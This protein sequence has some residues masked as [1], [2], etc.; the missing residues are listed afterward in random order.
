LSFE[1]KLSTLIQV[2]STINAFW[3][4]SKKL[5]LLEPPLFSLNPIAIPPSLQDMAA[6]MDAM[7]GQR[8]CVNSIRARKRLATCARAQLTRQRTHP[9]QIKN[10][11]FF[12]K[13]KQVIEGLQFALNHIVSSSLDT[14]VVN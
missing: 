14:R 4:P 1:S 3:R 9:V 12:K 11:D 2:I 8:Q 5:P 10:G 7:D 13:I 6:R